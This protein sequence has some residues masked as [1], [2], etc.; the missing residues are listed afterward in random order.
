MC[1]LEIKFKQRPSNMNY[2]CVL[3]N[4]NDNNKMLFDKPK[5]K[6]EYKEVTFQQMHFWREM[7]ARVK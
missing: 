4:K 3:G 5:T 6:F 2:A 7:N 1:M